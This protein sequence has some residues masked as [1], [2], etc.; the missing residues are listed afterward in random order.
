MGMRDELP[1]LDDD[2]VEFQA[3]LLRYSE[4]VKYLEE[5]FPVDFDQANASVGHVMGLSLVVWTAL[6]P[7]YLAG[8]A[9]VAWIE[10]EIERW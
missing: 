9:Y 10:G 8:I 4:A 2:S 5:H 3:N 6:N 1:D 7:K